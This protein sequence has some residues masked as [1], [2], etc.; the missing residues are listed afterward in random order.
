M[1]LGN[2][3]LQQAVADRLRGR[4]MG[5]WM[6]S[7]QGASPLGALPAGVVAEVLSAPLAIAVNAV[8]LLAL[9]LALAWPGDGLRKLR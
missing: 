7:T 6:A 5:F 2:T 1:T 4:V 3:L 8:A 9:L